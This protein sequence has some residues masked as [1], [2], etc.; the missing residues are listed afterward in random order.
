MQTFRRTDHHPHDAERRGAATVETAL[1]LPVFFMVMLGI[2]EIG[3]FFMVSQLMTNAA[4]EGARIAIMTG[5]T[6][7]DVTATVKQVA[8]A[9]VGVDP[10]VVQVTIQVTEYSG[11]PPANNDVSK[12]NKRDLC[13]VTATVNYDQINLVPIKWLTGVAVL[14]QAAMRHE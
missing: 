7:N 11:N 6:N 13:Q 14:G 12:A 10:A 9:T 1:V 4:R 2:V 8:Q 5:S 3:R